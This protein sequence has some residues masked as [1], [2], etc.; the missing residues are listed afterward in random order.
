MSCVSIKHVDKIYQSDVRI[1]KD[2]SIEIDSGEFLVLLGPS[3]CGKTTLL[4]CIAG[5]LDVEGGRIEIGGRDVTD[6][7]PSARNI[8]MVFQSYALYPTKTVYG[9]MAFCLR[10]QR[11]SKDYID[12]KIRE[13]AALLQITDLLPRKP[14]T[15]SGGQKQRAAIGRAL[16]RD[17]QVCLFDEPLSNLDAKLRTEMRI[18][19]KRLHK[20]V[21]GTFIYVTHDQVEAM[22]LATRIAIMEGG[23]LSQVATPAELYDK[24]ANT[25]VAKFIGSPPM[26]FIACEARNRGGRIELAA[27][28]GETFNLGGYPFLSLPRDGQRVILGAR[29]E[30]FHLPDGETASYRLKLNIVEPLGPNVLCY[31][32]MGG[33]ELIAS[34]SSPDFERARSDESLR[35]SVDLSRASVFDGDTSLRM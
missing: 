27:E 16:V 2:L 8:A 15:L 5:L 9:N 11:K 18:E 32:D 29:P 20:K 12:S 14:A 33:T 24:P 21:Q 30:C 13:T 6:L 31:C 7:D 34:L 10:M 17:A 1:L 28:G 3:G 4:N 23:R 35:L 26:N 25:F 19:L 22:T